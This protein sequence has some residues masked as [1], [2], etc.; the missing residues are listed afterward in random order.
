MLDQILEPQEVQN[1]LL[2]TKLINDIYSQ[3]SNLSKTMNKLE[4]NMKNNG[5]EMFTVRNLK[6][7]S[8]VGQAGMILIEDEI[9]SILNSLDP[10]KNYYN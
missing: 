4:Q 1:G 9:N 3:F 8:Q 10:K 7:V 5:F 2:H 6:F